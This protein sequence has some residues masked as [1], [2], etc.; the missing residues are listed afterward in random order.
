MEVY[1]D[2]W[3]KNDNPDDIIK[4]YNEIGWDCY[5][6]WEHEIMKEKYPELCRMFENHIREH[7]TR[8]NEKAVG[9][10]VPVS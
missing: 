1:G 7:Q 6:F 2:Y 8:I 10:M 3:H 4:K 9:G 5:V